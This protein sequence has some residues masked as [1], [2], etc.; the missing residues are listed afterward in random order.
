VTKLAYILNRE[1]FKS[2]HLYPKYQNL[3][4]KVPQFFFT[5][6]TIDLRNKAFEPQNTEGKGMNTYNAMT[7]RV[8]DDVVESVYM[9]T[10]NTFLIIITSASICFCYS[11][12]SYQLKFILEVKLN[13]KQIAR[14]MKVF[15]DNGTFFDI[16]TSCN[17]FDRTWITACALT[18][19][20]EVLGVGYYDGFIYLTNTITK[21]ILHIV[22]AHVDFISC[23]IFTKNGLLLT[24]GVDSNIKVWS[25]FTESVLTSEYVFLKHTDKITSMRTFLITANSKEFVLS[26]DSDGVVYYWEIGSYKAENYVAVDPNSLID[27]NPDLVYAIVPQRSSILLKQFSFNKKGCIKQAVLRTFDGLDEVSIQA[28]FGFNDSEIFQPKLKSFISIAN[29]ILVVW[30]RNDSVEFFDINNLTKI[31]EIK[32]SVI[33]N[34]IKLT[35]KL[36]ELLLFYK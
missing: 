32:L 4:V 2:L 6:K 35:K 26:S 33:P 11:M 12:P 5:Y 27:G 16:E 23:M 21:D 3:L 34:M 13:N 24:G 29:G 9:T 22:Q 8:D 10:E 14:I 7:D 1:D 31:Y 30:T 28:R 18:N 17:T 19:N 15:Q 20:G 36:N 25:G